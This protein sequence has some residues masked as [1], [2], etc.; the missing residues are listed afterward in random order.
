MARLE[1]G[2]HVRRLVGRT[3]I[4][5]EH[6]DACGDLLEDALERFALARL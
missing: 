1:V 2:H 4:E 6:L 3:T 5:N